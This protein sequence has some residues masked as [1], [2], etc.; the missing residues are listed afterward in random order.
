MQEEKEREQPMLFRGGG[1]DPKELHAEEGGDKPSPKPSPSGA[2]GKPSP[3]RERGTASSERECRPPR[4]P[5]GCRPPGQDG[6]RF[7]GNPNPR[8]GPKKGI[9]RVGERK[10]QWKEKPF[11][12]H[13]IARL[14]EPH[15]GR[16]GQE[17]PE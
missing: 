15:K 17:G 2:R 11:G 4:L 3:A 12:S 6:A 16:G 8:R 5:G 7:G 10:E 13:E 9:G 14:R 1:I